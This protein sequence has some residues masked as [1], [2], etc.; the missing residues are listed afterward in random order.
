MSVWHH[1]SRFFKRETRSDVASTSS[2][3]R[4]GATSLFVYGDQ[5]AMSVATVFR[6]VKL[7]SESVANLPLQY[8]KRKDGIFTEADNARLDYIL[9]VQPDNAINAFDFWRQVVQELLLDG[10]AYIV[11]VYNTVGM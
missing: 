8:L 2:A 4:T 3:A 10:N 9:N 6:C 7:L 11:P 5:T 1:I